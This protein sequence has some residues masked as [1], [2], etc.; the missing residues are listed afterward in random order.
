MPRTGHVWLRLAALTSALARP[1]EDEEG[2]WTDEAMPRSHSSFSFSRTGNILRL[3]VGKA[4]AQ[5]PLWPK[6]TFLFGLCTPH[7]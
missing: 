1:S 2:L 4:C 7:G 3:Q 6:S 5:V